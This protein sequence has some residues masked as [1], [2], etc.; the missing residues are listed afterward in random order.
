MKI[1][2]TCIALGLALAGCSKP[3][4]RVEVGDREKVL[5]VGNGAEPRDLDPQVITA[6]TDGWICE[7]LFENLVTPDP[8]TGQPQ[9]AAAVSWSVSDDGLTYTFHLRPGAKWSNGDPVTAQ[10]FLW[11]YQRMLT[12]AFAAEYSYMLWVVKNAEKFNKGELKDFSRVGFSAPDPM[13]LRVELARPTPYFMALIAHQSWTPVHGATLLKYGAMDQRGTAWTRPGNLVGNG[14]FTLAE[15]KPNDVV[16]VKRNSNYWDAAS[17]K[18]NEIRF[19]PIE[20]SATEERAFRSGQLHISY[21]LPVE[22]TEVY[23]QQHTNELRVESWPE[24]DYIGVNV[25]RKPF[26]DVRVRR[27]LGMAI[28]RKGI[29]DDIRKRGEQPA[30]HYTPPM[31]GYVARADLPTDYDAARRL[32]A[33]AGYP[34]GKGFPKVELLFATSKAA[35]EMVEAIQATWKKE[36]N[37]DVSLRNEE[38]KVFLD[39]QRKLQ[40][41]VCFTLW[42]GDYPDPNTFLD[43]METD[44]GNNDTGWSNAEYDHLISRANMTTDR[45]Q[46]F[47]VFQQAEELLMNQAPVLPVLFGAHVYLV[48]PE[49]RNY[50]VAPG[51]YVAYKRVDLVAP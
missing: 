41:D 21:G 1:F 51:S 18:L 35:K 8:K 43:M 22:K 27:A 2:I 42:I 24:I 45:A 38:F 20:N 39:T 11:S 4:T 37:I 14:P 46:R 13:T 40:Y 48:R 50:A 30:H 34:D 7:T 15:W 25:K 23:R 9:P 16:A 32:L 6:L 12:P 28:D 31:P 44:N 3:P 47:E 36:L 29:T 26:D 49:V 5:Y 17:V 33:E 19:Y 10:D